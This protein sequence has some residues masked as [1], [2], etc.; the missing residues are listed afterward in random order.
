MV[1][2]LFVMPSRSIFFFRHFPEFL[3]SAIAFYYLPHPRQKLLKKLPRHYEM[4]TYRRINFEAWAVLDRRCYC[5]HSHEKENE[6]DILKK[7]R[8]I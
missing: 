8:N 6:S 3:F 4:A 1:F 5:R 7:P 2:R